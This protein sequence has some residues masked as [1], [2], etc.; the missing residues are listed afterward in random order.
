MKYYLAIKTMKN[1]CILPH[2]C[3]SATSGDA[4]GI[5]QERPRIPRFLLCGMSSKAG[6]RRRKAA[7]VAKARGRVL[8]R[9]AGKGLPTDT[10]YVFEMVETF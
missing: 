1:R 2:G 8:G 5:K 7:E 3:A 10:G 4:K 6:L 9:E